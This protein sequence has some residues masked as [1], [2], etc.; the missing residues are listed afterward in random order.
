MKRTK[1]WMLSWV[2]LLAAAVGFTACVDDD[3]DTEMPYL[4]VTPAALTFGE[5]GVALNGNTININ[6]NRAW[7]ITLL[8]ADGDTVDP[9][10]WITLS[11]YEGGGEFCRSC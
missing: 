11:K 10:E 2:I 9:A 8:A 7:N 1:F 6:T 5:D 4:E 3:E